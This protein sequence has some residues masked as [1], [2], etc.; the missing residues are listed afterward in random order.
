MAQKDLG[1]QN[2]FTQP[3]NQIITMLLIVI[4]VFVGGYFLYPA[5]SP[6]FVASPYLNGFIFIVFLGGL[7]SCFGQ[8]VSL[9]KSVSWIEGF[10]I[11]RVG[12]D[13]IKPPGLMASLAALLSDSGARHALTS[14]STRSILD[15]AA[16]RLDE[17]REI[18]RYIINLLIFLGLLGTFYGLATTV[19][20]V[21][22]TIRSLAPQEGSTGLDVFAKL[23]TGLEAQLGGMGT[24]FGSSL[25]GLA[26]SLVV[27]ILDL[28]AGRG[29]NRFYRELEEWL[30]SI[31]KIIATMPLVLQEYDKGEL[32][33]NTKLSELFPNKRLKDKG[34]IPLKEMLSHYARLRPWIPFYEETLDRKEEPK[35]RFYKSN[36]KSSFSTPVSENLFLKTNYREKIF[37]SIINSEL[38]EDLEYKYSDLPFYFLKFWFED[39]YNIPLNVLANDRVFKRL[40]LKRTMF[41]PH[42][43]ISLDEMIEEAFEVA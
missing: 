35:S 22:D 15:S 10:V 14:T 28:F 24:A 34:Q 13:L 21:V 31:T 9:V 5:V 18:T 12:H 36:S 43:K 16:T 1:F 40:G 23:M 2:Q 38:R 39:K 25:L 17:G 41:N 19:P 11:D 3:V 7:V 30:S 42:E 4:A 26:G 32:K 29:Q 27:G 8:V 20:A 6:I 33:L 37:K